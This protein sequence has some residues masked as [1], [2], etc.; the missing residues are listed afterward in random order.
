MA[1][2]KSLVDYFIELIIPDLMLAGLFWGCVCGG[3]KTKG[4]EKSK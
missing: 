3:S 1:T 2:K 4:K